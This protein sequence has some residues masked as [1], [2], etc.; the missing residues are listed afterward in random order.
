MKLM[1]LSSN[2]SKPCF[3]LQFKGV[4]IMMDCGLDIA[5]VQNFIP[6]PVISSSKFD[7]LPNWTPPNNQPTQLQ[8]DVSKELKECGG[9]VF[10]DGTLEF[11]PPE[12]RMVNLSQV[13]V[14]LISNYTCM[15]ALPYITEYSGFKGVVYATD[16][17]VQIGRQYM[18]EL[19]TYVER[20]SK[21]KVSAKWKSEDI[22]KTL[23]PPVCDAVHPSTWKK[24]YTF[25]DINSCL[26]HVQV[27]GFNEKLEFFGA[28]DAMATSSGVC[29]GSSNWVISSQYEKIVYIAGTSTL[30]THPKPMETGPLKNADVLI[31]SCLSQR[32]L[33]NPD[34]MIGEFCLKAALTVKNGGNVLV[35]CYPSG[36]TYDLFECLS[37]HLD[38]CAMGQVPMYFLSPVS[39]STLAYANIFSEWLSTAKQNKVYLPEPPFPHAELLNSGRLQNF[40]NIH[41]GLSNSFKSPC[42]VFAGHPSL[43]MGDV[44]H[45]LELWGKSSAN[46]VMFTEPDFPY[47]EALAPYQ[48][49]AMRVCYCPIDISLSFS[50]ANKL[51]KDLRPLHLVLAEDYITPPN[52]APMRTDLTIEWEPAPLT[53]KRGEI[54]SL[55]VKRQFERIEIHPRLASTLEP[56]EVKPGSLITMVTGCIMGKDNKNVLEPIPDDVAVKKKLKTSGAALS[57][58]WGTLNIKRF[59]DALTENGITDVKLEEAGDGSIIHLPNED[60]LIQIEPESTHIICE[61]N[62]PIRI[63]IRDTLLKCLSKF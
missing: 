42:I 37:G 16:P 22:I 14:I 1:C 32:P 40:T 48:P 52:V 8:R 36:I 4:N 2:H 46:A 50:Q 26:A 3:V 58:L 39:D 47:L 34:A 19:V 20:F 38:S 57:Y 13:D 35:P 10:V 61:G 23:P 43:R 15:L 24:C 63:K 60:T 41:S 59:V 5:Q 28:L 51:I 7:N 27:I 31:L 33:A 54:L 18:E 49:L 21:S 11:L 55:P 29:L 17:T 30:T 12:T 6:L 9:R 56:V 44:V 45:F 25:D 53:Y 62:E